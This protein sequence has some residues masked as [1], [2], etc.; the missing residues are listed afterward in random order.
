MKQKVLLFLFSNFLCVLVLAGEKSPYDFSWLDKDKEIYVLQNRKYTKDHKFYASLMLGA[1][2]SGAFISSYAM[3]ART[4]YFFH[5][6]WG[7]EIL[8]SKNSGSENAIAKSVRTDTAAIPF[9][10]K[11]DHYFAG[12]LVWSPFYGKVNTF[13]KIVYFDWTLGAGLASI[14]DLNNRQS[15]LANSDQDLES[16]SHIGFILDTGL[17]FYI[18][19]KWSI[20]TDVTMTLYSAEKANINGT[21]GK[22][23]F[24]NT[25]LLLGASYSF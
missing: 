8:F 3:Q 22:R 18:N 20:R 17:R 13:K 21:S 6:E 7:V 9:Y 23:M 16:E 5:E 4:G 10:R 11:M 15:V 19:P 25:D 2:T 24:T 12:M 14:S 1:T